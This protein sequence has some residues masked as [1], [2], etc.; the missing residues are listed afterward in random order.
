MKFCMTLALCLAMIGG[1]TA[2]EKKNPQTNE[3]NTEFKKLDT[4]GDGLLSPREF[5]AGS[6]AEK[7]GRAFAKLD[8]DKSGMIS[9]AEFRSGGPTKD[10]VAKG[11]KKK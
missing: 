4:N 5:A 2:K 7:P 6:D 10:K 1:A 9:A 11:K 8:T 3:R